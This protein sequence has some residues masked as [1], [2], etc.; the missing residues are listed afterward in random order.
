MAQPEKTGM[1]IAK[2]R[3]SN[4]FKVIKGNRGQKEKANK[5]I[6]TI[7]HLIIMSQ[8]LIDNFQLTAHTQNI[9][10]ILT[11]YIN[12]NPDF[13]R[14]TLKIKGRNDIP[15][16]L[17]KGICLISPPGTGKSFIFM[18]LLKKY[19]LYFPDLRY[20]TITT[21]K[22]EQLFGEYGISGWEH[23]NDGV[24]VGADERTNF[25]LYIDDIGTETQRLLHYGSEIDFLNRVIDIRVWQQRKYGV[26]THTSTNLTLPQLKERYN[27]RTFSRMFE[28]F[29]FI[30]FDADVDFR[31]I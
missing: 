1:H 16:S 12:K 11:E 6:I 19:F 29:N 20:R 3:K 17:K 2:W 18:E 25:N 13:E 28:L 14:R 24:Y 26:V 8:Q 30:V 21:Y 22:L 27:G 31:K 23:I 15:F 10:R 9:Y 5:P 7:D 4:D